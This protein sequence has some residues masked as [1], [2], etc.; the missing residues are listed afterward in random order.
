MAR[1]WQLVDRVETQE[2]ALD[3]RQ[4]DERDFLITIDNRVLMNSL[5]NGSEIVLAE[6]ACE[7]LNNKRNPRVL[8]G[9]LGMGFTLQAALD[10]LPVGAE[11]VVAEFNPTVVQP[12]RPSSGRAEDRR[13]ASSSRSG[14]GDAAGGVSVT[15]SARP[16]REARG[17][18]AGASRR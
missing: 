12:T 9:G 7:S 17:V 2:G 8:V 3:L 5:A 15:K 1:P 18:G 14:G 16:A 10:H 13:A 4:R 6:L 11:V